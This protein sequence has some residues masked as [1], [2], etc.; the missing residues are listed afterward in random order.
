MLGIQQAI[1][2]ICQK[3]VKSDHGCYWDGGSL[4]LW[5]LLL[6]IVFMMTYGFMFQCIGNFPFYLTN[7]FMLQALIKGSCFIILVLW[8]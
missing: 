5:F 7:L 8:L 1:F 3:H 2:A 4:L 6:G